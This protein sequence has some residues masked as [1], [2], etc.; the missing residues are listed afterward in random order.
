MGELYSW[1]DTLEGCLAEIIVLD[2][3]SRNLN[4]NSARAWAQDGM[5]LLLSQEVLRH[6]EWRSLDNEKQAFLLMPWMHSESRVIHQSAAELFRQINDPRF[7]EYEH[8]HREII[9]RF[10]RYPHRNQ[11]LGRH[12]TPE[13][14]AYLNNKNSFTF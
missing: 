9:N 14:I 4:R 13:E 8:K 2:Q 5:A 11:H 6:Y 1:R 3:F 7:A 12:S 10:G